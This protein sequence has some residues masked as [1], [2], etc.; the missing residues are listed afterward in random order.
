MPGVDYALTTT[1]TVEGQ[2][3]QIENQKEIKSYEIVRFLEQKETPTGLLKSYV[4]E[5]N[6]KNYLMEM[7]KE[8]CIIV[9]EEH[10]LV[11]SNFKVSNVKVE[12]Q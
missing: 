2:C 11:Y 7:N 4:V 5:E 12:K 1:I 10:E 3:I 8:Y 6:G 9:K